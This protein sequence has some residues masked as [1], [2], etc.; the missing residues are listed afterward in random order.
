MADRMQLAAEERGDLADFLDTLSEEQWAAPSLCERWNVRDVVAHVISYE[1]IGWPGLVA[2]FARGR[3]SP[4]RVNDI[5]LAAYRDRPPEEL[6]RILR[7]HLKPHG[8]TAGSGGGIGL[9][10]SL[11][12]HQDIRRA[13]GTQREVPGERLIEALG[14]SLRAPVLPSKK[15]A[16]GAATRTR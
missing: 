7:S 6:V 12:H 10:D 13:L 1:E 4:G 11:I 14:I 16:A 15:N 3:F 5:R 2:A 9:S 8:L